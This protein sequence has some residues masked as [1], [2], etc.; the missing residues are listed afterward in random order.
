MGQASRDIMAKWSFA[1]D[2]EGLRLALHSV[3]G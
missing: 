3:L 2:I 1:E